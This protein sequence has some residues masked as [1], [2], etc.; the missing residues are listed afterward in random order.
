M[1]MRASISRM[2]GW[3]GALAIVFAT[4]SGFGLELDR[5]GGTSSAFA[6]APKAGAAAKKK[7]RK[8]PAKP[9]EPAKVKEKAKPEEAGAA[10]PSAEEVR[11]KRAEEE[12][13]RVREAK[14]KLEIEGRKR[15]Q[16]TPGSASRWS[17]RGAMTPVVSE[18]PLTAPLPE[19]AVPVAAGV[20]T[21][22]QALV[23]SEELLQARLYLYAYHLATKGED[24][25]Y[26]DGKGLGITALVPGANRDLDLYRGRATLSY[27][28]IAGSNFGAN[29]DLE[30]R[31]RSSGSYPTDHRINELYLSYGLTD[32]RRPGSP[33]FGIA[34]GRVAIREAGYAQ[35]DGGALRLRLSPDLNLGVFGGVTGNPFGYNW[36]LAKNQEISTDWL[37]GGTFLSYRTPRIFTNGAAVV[38]YANLSGRKGLDRLYL[39]LDAD[40]LATESINLFVTGW[41]DVIGGTPLQNVEAVASF[42]PSDEISLRLGLGRFSTLIYDVSTAHTYGV[43][44]FV[45]RA[46]PASLTN[47]NAVIVDENGTPI[48]PY[49]AIRATA[50]YNALRARAGYRPIRELEL[51]ASGDVLL[52]DTSAT[53]KANTATAGATLKV[54]SLRVMPAIGARYR[55]PE[56]F[57]ANAQLTYIADGQSRT[58]GIVQAGLGRG[59]G[60]FYGTLDARLFFGEVPGADGGFEL[61]FTFPREI[62]FG[63][64]MAR[65]ML[66]YYR[67]NVALERPKEGAG[68][69]LTPAD[70]RVLIPLQESFLG[71]G[72][73]EWRL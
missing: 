44:R 14:K 28:R 64:L 73:L 56:L 62:S 23:G 9:P 48:V 3:S 10:P 52:R 18:V 58:H 69:I 8:R 22:G 45:N 47:P 70:Q 37:R 63:R 41:L 20:E 42:A 26:K 31:S 54:S 35:A 46:G 38:T 21:P 16:I 6:A 1:R 67:E 30:Y 32:F 60:G 33:S 61:T 59:W 27:S 66:R 53:D 15:S 40:Y 36:L 19:R 34:I 71:F 17:N 57:D 7:R 11:A 2:V 49:D 5:I 39:Y 65:A 12:E 24:T 13:R 25:V 4:P 43:D 72:G 29:L 55:N 51:Y 50:V 68:A